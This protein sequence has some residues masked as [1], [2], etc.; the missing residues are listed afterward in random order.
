MSSEETRKCP[1]IAHS[2]TRSIAATAF[3]PLVRVGPAFLTQRVQ[4]GRVS[5]DDIE[6]VDV[7]TPS[8]DLALN[9]PRARANVHVVYSP[10]IERAEFRGRSERTTHHQL[11]VYVDRALLVAVFGRS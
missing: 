2:K 9:I 7:L 10:L 4:F 3:L 5:G 11:A 1:A 8:L 6:N